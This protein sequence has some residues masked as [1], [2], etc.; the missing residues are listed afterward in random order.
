[1][2][3]QLNFL[4]ELQTLDSAIISIRKKIHSL[5][6][7]ISNKTSM[8]KTFQE[9]YDNAQKGLLILEKKKKDKE[10]EI[11]EFEIKIKKLKGK[12]S[13][14]KT[15]KEYQAYIKEVENLQKEMS[16]AEDEL[17]V[18]LES[19]DESRK[20]IEI[21]KVKLNEEEARLEEIKKKLESE[22]NKTE[23][24]LNI[25][26]NKRKEISSKIEKDIY[27]L[28]TSILKVCNGQAVVEVKNEICK[29]C[30]LHIP[31]QQYVKIKNNK[32]IICCHQCRRILYYLNPEASEISNV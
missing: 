20:K 2:N 19:F 18:I 11:E 13:E 12:T 26:M 29:G 32:E 21:E 1:V 14:I 22:K 28:Y 23:E 25:L 24:E 10:R 16:N 17:L 7:S 8:L 27:K 31:P 4:I 5:P 6:D 30:N 3:E 9:S 15:N